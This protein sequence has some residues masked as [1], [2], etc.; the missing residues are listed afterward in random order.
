MAKKRG[1][2]LQLIVDSKTIAL[3]T[4]CVLNTD[5]QMTESRTKD[6]AIGPGGDVDFV[7]WNI[8][9]ENIVGATSGVTAQ[10]LY[11][12]LL[13]K[14]LAGTK[15]TVAM[16]MVQNATGAIPNTDWSPTTTADEA[17]VPCEGEAIIKSVTLNTPADNWAT[18][19]VN[20]K[21]VGPLSIV[22][23]SQPTTT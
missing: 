19:S 4:N 15:V 1:K 22:S 13:E 16:K 14:H 3:A 11:K 8:S 20:F 12:D 5:A 17:F 18:V 9:S 21:G 7:D 10:M 2:E 6:D 23:L